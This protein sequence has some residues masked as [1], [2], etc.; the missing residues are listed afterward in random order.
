MT[1]SRATWNHYYTLDQV[2]KARKFKG[3]FMP[4]I[5]KVNFIKFKHYFPS[6]HKFQNCRIFSTHGSGF[7]L[8]LTSF[9]N[10][11]LIHIFNSLIEKV[12]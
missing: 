12:L 3:R 11:S 4:F 5:C 9:Q 7:F 1:S 8:S 2:W 6:N 10:E